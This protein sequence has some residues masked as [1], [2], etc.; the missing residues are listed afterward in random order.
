MI[1]RFGNRLLFVFLIAQGVMACTSG[2]KVSGVLRIKYRD[3]GEP[4]K[5]CCEG[6]RG[7]GVCSDLENLY[8]V[9]YDLFKSEPGDPCTYTRLNRSEPSP[10]Q[11]F[12]IKR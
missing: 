4:Y 5:A 8:T 1:N 11:K 12:K 10:N 9:S 2:D 7:T 6:A 3:N